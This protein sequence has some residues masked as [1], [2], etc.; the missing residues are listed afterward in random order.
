MAAPSSPRPAGS[1]HL[2]VAEDEPHIRRILVTLLE[3]QGFR[4]DVARDGTEALDLLGT[5][6]AYDAILLDLLMP[7][8]TGLEVLARLRALPGYGTTPVLLL[9]AKGQDADRQEAFA[10][11]AV[12]FLTKPFS[13]KKL[14]N[15]LDEILSPGERRHG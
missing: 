7:G 2:M 10:L 15:R 14:V 11:G 8:F 9:S 12:D 5:G 1:L 3:A 13:P 4:V 6:V